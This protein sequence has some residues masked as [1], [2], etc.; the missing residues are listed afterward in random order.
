MKT[1]FEEKEKKRLE[2]KCKTKMNP[3]KGE[4]KNFRW[5]AVLCRLAVVAGR[6]FSDDHSDTVLTSISNDCEESF[7]L[8]SVVGGSWSNLIDRTADFL[9]TIGSPPALERKTI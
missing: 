3:K 4:T 7:M 2:K 9:T 5:C 6:E 8:L 1:M